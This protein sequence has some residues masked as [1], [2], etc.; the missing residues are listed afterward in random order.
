MPRRSLLILATVLL[1]I[2]AGLAGYAWMSRQVAGPASTGTALVGGP[3]TLTDQ[4]GRRVTEKDFHGKYMLVF[5]GYTYCPD[6]CPTELQVMMAALD[7]M[8]TE[9]E[10]IQPIFVSVD[11]ARDTP[12]VM[13]SYVE[14]FGPRLVGL[15]GS[16]EEV[17][18]AAKA[19]RV[20]YARSGN[21]ASTED[22]LVDHSSIIYLMGP[23][24]RFVK[25]FTY[26][27]DAAKLASELKEAT[28]TS[29]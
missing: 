14:N 27:T 16:P 10:K 3:F 23:D 15:T 20:Y 7:Q 6:I 4:N 26:T 2:A 24:G 5:F 8:G 29:L 19:Y 17:A 12:D 25:H 22:Y 21:T 13:K 28:G 1:V 11:P 18:A 9:A